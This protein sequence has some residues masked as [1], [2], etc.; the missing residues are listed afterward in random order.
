MITVTITPYNASDEALEK[1][2][3]R[4]PDAYLNAS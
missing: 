3:T 1:I 4:Y 2:Q